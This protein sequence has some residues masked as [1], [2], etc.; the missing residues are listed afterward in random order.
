M[1]DISRDNVYFISIC[2]RIG[3]KLFVGDR[4][5][6]EQRDNQKTDLGTETEQEDRD[7][8]RNGGRPEDDSG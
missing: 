5:E 7:N 1:G 3:P 4:Y 8:V 2:Q 6:R